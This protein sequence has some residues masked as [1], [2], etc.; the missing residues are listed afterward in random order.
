MVARSFVTHPQNADRIEKLQKEIGEILPARQ[1]Y[2]V[3][4]SDF[5]AVKARLAAIRN[6]RRDGSSQQESSNN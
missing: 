6:Q 2:L 3:T 4:N 1:Q 5:D